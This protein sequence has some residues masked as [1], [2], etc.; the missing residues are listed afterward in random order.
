VQTLCLTPTAITLRSL[1]AE[2]AVASLPMLGL[3]GV[4]LITVS[5]LGGNTLLLRRK[6]TMREQRP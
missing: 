3:M 6:H 4:P 5:L 2:N 1:Q